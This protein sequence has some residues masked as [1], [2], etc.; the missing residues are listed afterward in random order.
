MPGVV[1]ISDLA[2]PWCVGNRLGGGEAPFSV[3][4]DRL[5]PPSQLRELG[6]LP[7]VQL[8]LLCIHLA[9]WRPQFVCRRLM[10]RPR[11]RTW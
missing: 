4:T 10:Y 1:L 6:Q 8:S 3:G 5:R 2:W 7:E 9:E 11:C